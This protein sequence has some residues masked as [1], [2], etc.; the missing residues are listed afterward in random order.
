MRCTCFQFVQLTS[1]SLRGALAFVHDAASAR[2]APHGTPGFRR[3]SR[4]TL[5]LSLDTEDQAMLRVTSLR[6]TLRFLASCLL[7]A[8]LF[9]TAACSS[10]RTPQGFCAEYSKQKSQYL[11]T[12]SSKSA[13]LNNSDPLTQ[14]IGGA[15]MT[16]QALGDIVVMFDALDKVAPDDIEPDVAAIHDSLQKQLDS[17]GD[18]AQHPVGGLLSGLSAALA[19]QGSWQRVGDYVKTNCDPQ[20]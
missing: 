15:A 13:A 11:Q 3:E 16:V 17:M 5:V 9:A 4:P 20:S 2:A 19:T 12:Y 6:C 7:V 18:N 10:A 8:P 1:P 14:A